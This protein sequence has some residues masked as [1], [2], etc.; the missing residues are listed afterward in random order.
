MDRAIMAASEKQQIVVQDE[1]AR[2]LY[3]MRQKVQWDW[4]SGLNGARRKGFEKGQLKGRLEG[5]GKRNIEIAQKLLAEGTTIEFVQ[6]I[7]GLDT[8]T[9]TRLS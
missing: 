9:T 4:V 2:E 3:E 8:R 1:A 6:R 7:T 5:A